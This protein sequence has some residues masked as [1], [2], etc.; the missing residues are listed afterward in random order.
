MM[1]NQDLR[2][3]RVSMSSSPISKPEVSEF[4][5]LAVSWQEDNRLFFHTFA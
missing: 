2:K 1:G 4:W 3:K 5:I